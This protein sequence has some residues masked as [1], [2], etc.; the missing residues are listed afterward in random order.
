MVY[1]ARE[2]LKTLLKAHTY[3]GNA[4]LTANPVII[5]NSEADDKETTHGKIVIDDENVNNTEPAGNNFEFI[6]YRISVRFMFA[7]QIVE[8]KLKAIVFESRK[9]MH[10]NN[11]SATKTYTYR[12]LPRWDGVIQSGEINA[13]VESKELA[14]LV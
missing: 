11:F 5:H 7:S 4:A 14:T 3:S 10:T 6:D 9:A 2:A 8:T 12:M 1:N 13:I